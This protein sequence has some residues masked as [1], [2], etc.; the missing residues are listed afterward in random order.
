MEEYAIDQPDRSGRTPL[1]YAAASGHMD[2]TKAL[3]GAHAD[4]NSKARQG[5]TPL[6]FAILNAHYQIAAY[7]LYAGAEINSRDGEML[8]DWA[9][10][11][12]EVELV[13]RL[14]ESCVSFGKPVLFLAVWHGH[15]RIVRLLLEF[16]RF[17]DDFD[18]I[19]QDLLCFAAKTR[20]MDVVE[21]A[22]SGGA[23]PD[24]T[25]TA[26]PRRFNTPLHK[27]M[28]M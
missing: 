26:A 4:V 22:F 2:T 6:S 25:T 16:A 10:Y 24:S 28:R 11:Q 7:L 9:V 17:Q 8:L 21:E 19:R 1:S 27:V 3:V 20:R 5:R 18:Q 13:Q 14:M 15:L 23:K 12:G